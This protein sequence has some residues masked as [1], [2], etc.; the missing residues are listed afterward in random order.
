MKRDPI[1]GTLAETQDRE[2]A[3]WARDGIHDFD[4]HLPFY[5]RVFPFAAI[6]YATARVLDVG[7]GAISVF[8]R[9]AP[10]G[11][12]VHPY[13]PLAEDY[14]RIA[15]DKKFAIRDQ[16][17]AEPATLITFFNM[18]DHLERPDEILAHFAA[19]L[20]PT[21]RAWIYCHLDRPFAPEEHPQEFRFWQM[22]PLVSRHF[23]I[24]RSGIIREG[25]LFPY[26]W[27]AIC[28]PRRPSMTEPVAV[29]AHV[30]RAGAFYARFHAER[31][32]VKGI[33]LIGLRRLLPEE[34]QF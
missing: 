11:A 31:A 3:Y 25:R 19:H 2:L 22:A 9:E 17:P 16:L 7:A 18:L 23:R 5:R 30:A 32:V 24:V 10:A 33:K 12:N 26:A 27:W 13:D 14:N 28:E 34:L 6:D 20:A 21:G 4:R 29:A 1:G 8:E 15:P